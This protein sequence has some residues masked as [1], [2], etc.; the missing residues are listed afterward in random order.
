V[1]RQRHVGR[2][3]G[4]PFRTPDQTAR[5]ATWGRPGILAVRRPEFSPCVDRNGE[6]GLGYGNV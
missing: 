6:H 3:W 4:P 1:T 2:G 5:S